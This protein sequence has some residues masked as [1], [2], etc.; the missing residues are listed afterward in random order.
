M[1]GPGLEPS[2]ATEKR[3]M[4]ELAKLPPDTK[5][6]MASDAEGNRIYELDEVSN[7]PEAGFRDPF[8]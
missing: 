7:D 2:M 3:L 6:F 8:A 4:E 5:V 1:P